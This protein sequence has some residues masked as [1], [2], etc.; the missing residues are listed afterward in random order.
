MRL[1]ST[2]LVAAA[3]V[4]TTTSASFADL[5]LPTPEGKKVFD[6]FDN[7]A[8]GATHPSLTKPND[9]GSGHSGRAGAWEAHINSDKIKCDDC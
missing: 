2:L 8:P 1:F 5:T 6:G 7:P 4:L 9:T 3:L